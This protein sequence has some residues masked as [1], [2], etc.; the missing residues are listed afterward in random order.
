MKLIASKTESKF[1]EELKIAHALH[2]LNEIEF[3][4]K[5]VLES[6]GH[7]TNKCIHIKLIIGAT[8]VI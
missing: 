5:S 1:N 7:D 2:F 3:K 4:L 6:N 8:G